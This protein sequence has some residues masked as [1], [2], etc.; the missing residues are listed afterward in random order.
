MGSNRV[1]DNYLG[2]KISIFTGLIYLCVILSVVYSLLILKEDIKKED[3]SNLLRI[4]T[5][6]QRELIKEMFKENSYYL[7]N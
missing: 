4:E 7:E 1:K 3:K 6:N 5:S 2:K